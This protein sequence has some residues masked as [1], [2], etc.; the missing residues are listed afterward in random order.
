MCWRHVVLSTHNSWLPG[1]PRGFRSQHHKVHSSGD[2]KNRPPAGEHA[3]LHDY[4]KRISGDAVVIPLPC[5]SIVGK[6][7][8]EK[9]RELRLEILVLAVAGMHAHM[10]V[11]LPD[12]IKKVR[13]LIGRCKQ[14]ASHSIRAD[15]PGRVW[16]RDGSYKPID[17]PE[18]QKKVF[19]YILNQKGAWIW[20]YKTGYPEK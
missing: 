5:R 13:M 2:Y 4:S 20:S 8:L 6:A 17:G 18:Y 3:G 11:E 1:D 15:L 12:D 7:L 16:A 9:L 10:Q 19:N 14:K